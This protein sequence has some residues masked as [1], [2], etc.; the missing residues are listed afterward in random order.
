MTGRRS[1]SFRLLVGAVLWIAMALVVAGLA[2]TEIFRTQVEAQFVQR[3]ETELNA[4]AGAIEVSSDA[5]VSLARE[6]DQADFRKPYSGHYWQVADAAGAT[7]LYSR[8]LWDRPLT[9]PSDAPPNGVLRRLA[10]T[11][12]DGEPLIAV[13]RTVTAAE[14]GPRLRLV[15]AENAA[16]LD[17]P[18][19]RF[20]HTLIASLGVLGAGLALAAA[21]QVVLGLRPLH[22]LRERL[23]A[24]RAGRA[25]RLAGDFPSEIEPL[26]AELNAVLE[27]NAEVV[28]R[29]R[30][31]AS[32]LAHA[33]KT[34]LAV[35]AN[36]T[37]DLAAGEEAARADS[38]RR[39]TDLMRRQIDYHL[40]RARAAGT[41]R[42]PGQ[43]TPL[44]PE[45]G[46]LLRTM[47]QVHRERGLDIASDV[48]R[49]IAF[50]GERQDL[51][52]MLGTLLD[53]ACK[54]AA[55]RVRI[56]ARADGGILVVAVEDDGP[57]LPA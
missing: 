30:T 48:P 10:L 42:V 41:T 5:S 18:L 15:A 34:P 45:I 17:T 33:L 26:V 32:N 9:L 14:G 40:A 38:L 11:G 47:A 36:E 27:Q 52:E 21:L 39:Q 23:A 7:M 1:L 43:R 22:R 2:L 54:W 8:S 31:Q 25:E 35:L 37:A 44:A 19:E 51:H 4:L 16:F 3:L 13:E 46:A 6:P 53:N 49:E 20:E 55:Q 50:R 57:G 29:A 12:P 24:V 56:E 28:A